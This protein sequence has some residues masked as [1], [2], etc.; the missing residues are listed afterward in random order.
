L[1]VEYPTPAAFIEMI[2]D[3]Y[4][5]VHEHGAAASVPIGVTAQRQRC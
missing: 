3:E 1:I 2:S 5:K 4:A